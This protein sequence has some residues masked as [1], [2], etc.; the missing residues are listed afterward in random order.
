MKIFKSF[1]LACAALIMSACS[2]DDGNG[3][4]NPNVASEAQY[5]AV[6]IVNVGTTPTRGSSTDPNY[7]DGTDAENKI[8]KVRFYFFNSDGSPYTL[9]GTEETTT[10]TN[11]NWLEQKTISKDEGSTSSVDKILNTVLVIKGSTAAAPA[12]MV[13]VINPETLNATTL[14][15]NGVVSLSD[16]CDG[17]ND[18]KFYDTPTSGSISDFV[19]TNSAYLEAGI[20]VCPSLV[21]GHVETSDVDA[22][23]NPVD[24]YVERVAAKVSTELTDAK[25]EVGTAATWG[26]GLYKTKDPVYT[27]GAN[28]KIYAVIEGWGVADEN[29]K[30]MVVK[31]IS[32]SWTNDNIGIN[33]WNTA[34]YHRC[35]WES[36]MPNANATGT[37]IYSNVNHAFNDYKANI[38]TGI[39]YTLPNTAAAASDYSDK[40]ENNMTKFLVAATLKYQDATGAWQ[41]AEV[42]KYRGVEYLGINNLKEAV[43][44]AYNKYYTKVGTDY[45]ELQAADI[46]FVI[47]PTTAT[48]SLKDYQVVPTLVSTVTEVYK[49]NATGGYDDVTTTAKADIEQFTADVRKNGKVY[50]YIPINHL[51]KTGSVAECGI[52]R[53]HWYKVKLNSITGLGTPVYNEDK[54]ID[55]TTPSDENTYLAARVNVL[56]W[57]VVTQNVDLGKK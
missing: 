41:K 56:Q 21:S 24:I 19:M 15:S 34:D 44:T 50:Y 23:N 11:V 16:L 26:D 29:K 2:S 3:S 12:K 38:K 47:T 5:L 43:A 1:P 36:M 42:C 40:K 45:K 22:K 54:T 33:P 37:S 25:F 39:K 10:G 51:G 27:Y 53:N 52:V 13:T 4:E 17:L 48:T 57:R 7:A 9:V 14:K 20:K 6:N 35:F 28:T 30:A 31:Q 32:D 8:N 55:P 46:D 49:K 18:T